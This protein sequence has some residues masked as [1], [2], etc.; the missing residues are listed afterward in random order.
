[1][2]ALNLLRVGNELLIDAKE[3]RL[4]KHREQRSPFLEV[5]VDASIGEQSRRY[6]HGLSG[7][8]CRERVA[9]LNM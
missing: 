1:M 7:R 3:S 6:P 8:L 5:D 4:V 2:I 9:P